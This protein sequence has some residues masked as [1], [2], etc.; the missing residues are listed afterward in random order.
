MIKEFVIAISTQIMIALR[1]NNAHE[2]IWKTETKNM[3][4]PRTMSKD[5][6]DFI[7]GG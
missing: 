6:T 1:T 2:V 3:P 7:I 4:T 5:N